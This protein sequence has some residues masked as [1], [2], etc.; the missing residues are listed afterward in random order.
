[1]SMAHYISTDGV[2]RKVTK[3]Y[4]NVGGVARSI[5]KAYVNAN[6]AAR[7]Y[8]AAGIPWRKWS[9]RVETCYDY[10]WDDRDV[11]STRSFT[12]SGG[13]VWF[14]T[15]GGY[16]FDSEDGFSADYGNYGRTDPADMVG[17]YSVVDDEV[18]QWTVCEITD[19]DRY[20]LEWEVVAS[21][22]YTTWD[23]Y[24]KGDTDY[25]IVYAP[26][27]ALPEEGTVWNGSAHTD[28]CVVQVDGTCYYYEK[29]T[30]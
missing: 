29:V 10:T 15:T 24:E 22:S 17:R 8:F 13:S 12:V 23:S 1:M 19:D 18:R 16:T 21:A 26:E 2:A 4:E 14:T 9:C 28:S 5:L 3:R 7:Q 11:G 6:G 20:Y 25:G 30:E 27:G